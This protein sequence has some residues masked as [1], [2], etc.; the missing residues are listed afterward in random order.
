VGQLTIAIDGPAASGKSTVA[1]ALAAR[2]GYLYLD[3]G[4]MYRAVTWAA[5]ERGVPI[6]DEAAISRLAESLLIEVKAAS[7]Q[8]G[9]QYDVLAD[10]VDITWQIREAE[11]NRQ[12]SPVSAYRGVRLALTEQQRRIADG[13]GVI[14][15]GRDIGTVVLPKAEVKIY[16]DATVEERARRRH[17]ENVSRGLAS[18]YEEVLADLQRRDY[19]DSTRQEAPLSVAEGATVIDSTHMTVDEVVARIVELIGESGGRGRARGRKRACRTRR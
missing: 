19:I 9:R 5:L 4:V 13:G 1:A 16:L 14:V 10:G 6:N 18:E 11:V 8:D 15:V 3:T 2:L 7:A 12:V 17:L